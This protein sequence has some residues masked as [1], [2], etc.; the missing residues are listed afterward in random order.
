MTRRPPRS[1]PT[2]PLF[3]YTSL[4]PSPPP[5]APSRSSRS[6]LCSTW[7][8]PWSSPS[9]CRRSSVTRH[10]ACP[11]GGP[12]DVLGLETHRR[13]LA[14]AA[15]GVGGHGAGDDPRLRHCGGARV[16]AGDRPDVRRW[17]ERSVGKECVSTCRARWSPSHKKKKDKNRK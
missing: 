15:A 9:A 12:S 2:V 8:S 14:A 5:T 13:H 4:F 6:S 17:E 16:A 7:R 11:A 10:A 1:T 3:P